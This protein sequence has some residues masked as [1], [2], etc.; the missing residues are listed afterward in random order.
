MKIFILLG[1][2]ML[3]CFSTES[4]LRSTSKSKLLSVWYINIPIYI[5]AYT[6]KYLIATNRYELDVEKKKSTIWR[7]K[8]IKGTEDR[9]HVIAND[10]D[11]LCLQG[12]FDSPTLCRNTDKKAEWSLT[13]SGSDKVGFKGYDGNYLCDGTFDITTSWRMQKK[14]T[15]TLTKV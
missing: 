12:F 11:Y 6:G 15:W 9:Y 7:I 10:V 13:T 3:I 4:K 8:L 1:L 14:E 2:A 5:Q